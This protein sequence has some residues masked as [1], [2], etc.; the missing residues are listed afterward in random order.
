MKY[1]GPQVSPWKRTS[2]KGENAKEEPTRYKDLSDKRNTRA[3][4]VL[5]SKEKE[6]EIG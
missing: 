2:C 1:K 6:F 3:G 5:G 4:F